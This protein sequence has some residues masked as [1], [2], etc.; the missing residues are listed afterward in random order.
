[1]GA[2]LTAGASVCT[3]RSVPVMC[4]PLGLPGAPDHLFH[5]NRDGTFSDVTEAAGVAEREPRFGFGVAWFDMDDDGRLDLFVANDSGP[6]HVYRNLGDGRFADVG[7][8]SGA[9]LDANGRTQAHMGVAV[10]D[11]DNDGRDDLHVTNFAD[12]Y[13]VLYRNHDGRS[14]S[15]V[16][17]PA[18]VAQ[19][20]IPFLG[21]GTDFLDYDNDGWLDLVVVNGHVYP[22]AD[23]LPWNTSYA[24]RALLFRNLAG[25]RFVEVG[26]A[27]GPALTT[28]RVARGSATGDLDDDGDVDLVVSTLD[29]PPLVAINDGGAAAGHW[30]TLRLI[31]D[32]AQHCPLDA[33]GSTVFVTAGG[34]RRRGEVASGRGQVSQSDLRVHV[35]LGTE[36]VVT[37]VEVRWANGPTTRYAIPKVDAAYSIDQKTGAVTAAPALGVARLRTVTK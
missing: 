37:A 19:P 17:Y 25:K 27:A 6:N 30:L 33:I 21:W 12:D 1:M 14:F 29:G 34:V 3:Y 13:N 10:G 5:N 28:P 35:G 22:A 4:G 7:Y 2:S 36:T 9:A 31:G 15:D 20:S 16:S 32:P 11:Y 8:A 23:R 18:G 26:A 24:Q